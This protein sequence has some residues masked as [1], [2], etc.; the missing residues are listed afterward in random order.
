MKAYYQKFPEKFTGEMQE[1][2]E[3]RDFRSFYKIETKRIRMIDGYSWDT[4]YEVT[5]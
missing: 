3:N 1:I 4:P 5:L 2:L